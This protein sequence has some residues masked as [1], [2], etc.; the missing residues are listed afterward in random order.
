[1]LGSDI[2][3]APDGWVLVVDDQRRPQGWLDTANTKAGQV[4]QETLHR[5]GTLATHSGSL[6]AALDAALSSPS[7]HGVVVDDEGRLIG[8]VTTA[9]VVELIEEHAAKSRASQS[10]AGAGT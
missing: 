10:P 2:S 1:V 6:R 3:A 9:E 4:G 5:G 8:T 7:G